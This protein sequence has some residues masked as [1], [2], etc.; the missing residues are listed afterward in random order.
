MTTKIKNG[1]SY[2]KNGWT[3]ISIKGKP[4]ERGYAY[5]YLCAKNFKEIQ[6]TLKFLMMEAYGQTWDFFIEKVSKEES[7]INSGGSITTINCYCSSTQ[8][9]YNSCLIGGCACA[10]NPANLKQV[11]TCVCP[12]GNCFDGSKCVK[13]TNN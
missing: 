3:Y 7:C 12:N 10:P 11:K 1:L 9:F 2:E 4:K 5:G 8:N 13:I 6:Q